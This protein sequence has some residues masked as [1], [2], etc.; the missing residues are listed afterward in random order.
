MKSE[1]KIEIIEL[2]KVLDLLAAPVLLESFVQKRG[3]AMLVDAEQVQ[4]L[5]AQC[6]QILLSAKKAWEVEGFSFGLSNPSTAFIDALGL[7]GVSVED[8]TYHA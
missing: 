3:A 8:L 6:L 7:M 2:Q 1:G 4:R 5:G